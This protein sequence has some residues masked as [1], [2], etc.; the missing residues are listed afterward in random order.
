M[1]VEETVDA[2][3][4]NTV[5]EMVDNTINDTDAN[6]IDETVGDTDDETVDNT[7]N[8]TDDNTVDE[9]VD[10]TVDNTTDETD[11]NTIDETVDNT[12]DSTVDN[13]ADNPVDN[14]VDNT[15]DN[16][17]VDATENPIDNGQD[18]EGEQENTE[19]IL[20]PQLVSGSD[21]ERLIN[22]L[23]QQA[24]FTLLD[25]NS[26]IS[27]GEELTEQQEECLGTFEEGFGQPLLAISCS[28]ALATGDIAL[29]VS[30]AA[31]YDT[32]TCNESVALGNA[33]GCILQTMDVLIDTTFTSPASGL[34]RPLFAGAQVGYAI[35]DST[36][37]AIESTPDE[38]TG[39]FLCQ[40]D[41]ENGGSTAPISSTNCDE[42]IADVANEIESRQ[43][44]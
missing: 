16:P 2:T 22:A 32:A 3:D 35:D 37:L 7:I 28:Q 17:P 10:T 27:Q 34:P 18:V 25:L 14:S 30:D 20:V 36:T 42:L 31:F 1:T 44:F 19:S 23:T 9:T 4:D 41:L 33:D 38:L 13:T 39:A 43:T 26:S 15:A 29:F 8:N 6:T 24:A 5:D 40:I 21:L 12:I 11:D